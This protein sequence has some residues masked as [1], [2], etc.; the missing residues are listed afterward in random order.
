MSAP[1]P[2]DD[3]SLMAAFQDGHH[4]AFTA[5]YDRHQASLLRAL[6]RRTAHDAADLAQAAFLS[7]VRARDRYQ[8]GS[9]FRAWLYAIAMNALRDHQRKAWRSV[10]TID[11]AV[12]EVAV[13]PP[14]T[15]HASDRV[16]RAALMTLPAAEREA[17]TLHHYDGFSFKEV[18][19]MTGVSESA[20]KVRAHRGYQRLRPLL[21]SVWDG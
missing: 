2:D 10:L 18:A 12:P 13:D 7:V 1:P 11:G 16:V 5:L 21:Q 8:R 20:A 19:Q 4:A 6:R 9:S 14:N 17:V 3:E 15:D